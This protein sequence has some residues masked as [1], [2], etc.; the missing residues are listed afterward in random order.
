MIYLET[1]QRCWCM[2]DGSSKCSAS[3]EVSTRVWQHVWRILVYNSTMILSNFTNRHVRSKDSPIQFIL[4]LVLFLLFV[5]AAL[6][7][8]KCRQVHV[9]PSITSIFWRIRHGWDNLF[10]ST[11]NIA[12]S[13]TNTILWKGGKTVTSMVFKVEFSSVGNAL[14]P[15][16]ASPSTLKFSNLT[17]IFGISIP[18]LFQRKILHQYSITC[19]IFIIL[20]TL[21]WSKTEEYLYVHR[22]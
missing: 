22:V 10:W 7:L 19:S 4:V 21:K 17:S 8:Q 2:C 11:S 15:T 1:L 16:Y 12:F 3:L 14:V 20:K 6:T 9:E 13:M 5:Y 18:T